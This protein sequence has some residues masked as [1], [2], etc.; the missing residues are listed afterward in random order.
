VSRYTSA[1]DGDRQEM[2]ATIGVESIDELFA[3]VP[4]S[5]RLE[6]PLS[7]GPGSSERGGVGSSR[8][9]PCAWRRA[10][11]SRPSTTKGS[12]SSVEGLSRA[13]GPTVIV[14]ALEVKDRAFSTGV[15]WHPEATL[16]DRLVSALV[17][18]AANAR[19]QPVRDL[20]YA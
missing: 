16:E 19:R 18:A 3:D 4:E 11:D 8:T 20:I 5:L 14:E 1:T 12:T 10:A 7:F 6:E 17:G 9:I 2:L 15:L 13:R